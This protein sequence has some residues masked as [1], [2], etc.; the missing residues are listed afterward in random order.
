M[1]RQYYLIAIVMIFLAVLFFLWSFEKRKPQTRE[2]VMLAVLTAMAIVGRLIFFMTPQFK[3]CAAVIIITAV[4]LG[5]EAGFLCGCLTAFISDFFFGQGPWTPWQMFAFGII[6]LVS[7]LIFS[8]A[9]KRLIE[10]RLFI[11]VYGFFIT[12][13]LYGMIASIGIRNMVEAQVDFTKSRNVIVAAIILV[14]A[15][16]I[17]LSDVGSISFKISGLTISLSG[18]AVASLVGIILN[19]LFPD[20]DETQEIKTQS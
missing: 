5:K 8:G 19:A 11:S 3:P 10:N 4:M 6:G 20:K 16:G 1:L 7:A 17:S 13:V 15:L 2:I 9:G 14:C 18:L 12:F